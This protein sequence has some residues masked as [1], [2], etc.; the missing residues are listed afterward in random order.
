MRTLAS[1]SIALLAACGSSSSGK[2]GDAAGGGDGGGDGSIGGP[3]T[4]TVTLVNHPMTPATYAF[5]VAYQDGGGAWQLAPAPSG[6]TYTFTINSAAWGFVWTCIPTV[7]GGTKRVELAYFSTGEKTSL[8]ETIP[9]ECSDRYAT[10][11]LNGTVQNLPV[12]NG[13]QTFIAYFGDRQATV[14]AQ[15]GV[16][17]ME[18]VPGTHDL[19]VGHVVTTVSTGGGGS[20]D[21]DKAAVVRGVTVAAT[22]TTT[23]PDVDYSQAGSSTAAVT[24]GSPGNATATTILYSAQA[25]NVAFAADGNAPYNSY[26]LATAAQTSGDVYDQAIVVTSSGASATVENWTADIAAQTYVAPTALGGATASVPSSTPYPEVETTWNPYA[27]AGGYVW[28]AQQGGGAVVGTTAAVEWTVVLGAGYVGT[29]PKFQMP[30]LTGITGWMA[31][32][33]FVTGTDIAGT[34]TAQ[35]STGGMSDFPAQPPAAVGTQRQFATS[36]W[37]VTP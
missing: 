23:A 29:A 20:V 33:Q 34:V 26:G 8:T 14:N 10:A 12:G 5:A 2:S 4:V 11:R 17:T 27:N 31:G 18:A 6:D 3:A 35:T 19:I 9:R 28:D 30:D 36:K 25:T 22:G 13:A 21:I 24:I 1:I 32:W 15:S 16:Y 37:T 7:A